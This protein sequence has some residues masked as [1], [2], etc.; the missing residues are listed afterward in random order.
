MS[1]KGIYVESF[2]RG[3]VDEVWRLTQTPDVHQRWDLRFTQ[4]EYLSRVSETA[5]QHFLYVTRLAPGIAIKGTGESLGEKVGA[6]GIASSALRFDSDQNWSLIRTGSGYWRYVPLSQGIR[7][8]TWYDY[9]VRF[10]FIGKLINLYLLRP[11]MGWATAWSFDRLRLWVEEGQTPE[12]S[13][14]FAMLQMIARVTIGFVWIWHGFVPKLL[15]R[16]A[17]E[18]LMLSQAGLPDFAL[19]WLG[20]VEIGFGTVM[21]LGTRWRWLFGL[22]TGFMLVALVAVAARSPQFLWTAF[23]PVTLNLCVIALSVIGFLVAGRTPSA[24]NCFRQPRREGS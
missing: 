21:L 12:M 5:P 1:A 24:R 10:G 7:F 19:P 23:N 11:A 8:L 20:L 9:D 4:I 18:R 22:N 16:D 17:T 6:D 13:F 3:S 2:I 15:F 14:L